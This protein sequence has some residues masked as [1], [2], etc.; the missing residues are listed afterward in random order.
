ML[1]RLEKMNQRRAQ[2]GMS[3]SGTQSVAIGLYWHHYNTVIIYDRAVNNQNTLHRVY[4]YSEA[5][6]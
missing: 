5:K 1:L 4:L 2:E 6:Y 3:S